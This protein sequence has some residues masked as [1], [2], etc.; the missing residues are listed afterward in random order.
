MRRHVQ[1]RRVLD[2]LQHATTNKLMGRVKVTH[3]D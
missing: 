3:Y 2:S 1:E